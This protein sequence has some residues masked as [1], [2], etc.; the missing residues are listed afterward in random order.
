MNDFSMFELRATE[1]REFVF[2][3]KSNKSRTM[4]RA[5]DEAKSREVNPSLA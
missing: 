2:N 3:D 4:G 1:L 5:K